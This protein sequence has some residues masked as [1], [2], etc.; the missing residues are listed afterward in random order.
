MHSEQRYIQ[1]KI[2]VHLSPCIRDLAHGVYLLSHAKVALFSPSHIPFSVCLCL[3]VGL[4][5]PPSLHIANIHVSLC[6]ASPSVCLTPCSLLQFPW[7]PFC[8]HTFSA[9]H[10]P[11]L[12]TLFSLH[13]HPTLTAHKHTL[14]ARF[15]S[16][17]MPAT[18]LPS[19]QHLVP[20]HKLSL[21]P[22]HSQRATGRYFFSG[23]LHQMQRLPSSHFTLAT[24][25]YSSPRSSHYGSDSPKRAR[26]GLIQSSEALV[27][28]YESLRAHVLW[29]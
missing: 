25:A 2:T 28:T 27:A 4:S 23:S 19:P 11:L 14:P 10:P 22:F 21:S 20:L 16:S 13:F 1:C 6:L 24:R 12:L 7:F 9:G 17:C 5:L 8:L 15:L 29:G 26:T 3:P 18:P